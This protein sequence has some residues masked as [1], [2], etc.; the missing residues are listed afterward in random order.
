MNIVHYGGR[1]NNTITSKEEI[2]KAGREIV[3]TKG[4]KEINMRSVATKCNIALGTLYNYYAN[5]DDLLLSVIESIWRDIF[6]LKSY[7]SN[8]F[9][10]FVEYI[11]SCIKDSMNKYPGF[12]FTHS[13]S[14]AASNRD[15]AKS[16]MQSCFEHI[17]KELLAVLNIDESIDKGVFNK[18]FTQED[19]VSFVFSNIV[20]ALVNKDDNNTL[21]EV[22]KRVL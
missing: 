1:L 18:D 12:F 22:I 21:I 9:I 20:L 8:S 7:N 4:L 5:K 3:A 15:K 14:I 2:L 10:D 19:F 16:A 6:H 11:I 13:M 17:K